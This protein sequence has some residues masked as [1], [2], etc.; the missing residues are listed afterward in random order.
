MYGVVADD[1]PPPA[2][3]DAAMV[4]EQRLMAAPLPN[5]G[6]QC[7]SCG[8]CN[9]PPFQCGV[10]RIH[11]T[12]AEWKDTFQASKTVLKKSNGDAVAA[13][14]AKE[15]G[16][17]DSLHHGHAQQPAGDKRGAGL[18]RTPRHVRVAATRQTRGARTTGEEA[19]V[20]MQ[21]WSIMRM[22]RRLQ[23]STCSPACEHKREAGSSQKVGIGPAESEGECQEVCR[24]GG[25]REDLPES[26]RG[27]LCHS[28]YGVERVAGR[29]R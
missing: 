27:K 24:L 23:V 19:A 6:V 17:Q 3:R 16:E 26:C 1:N 4:F 12:A 9:W 10:A 14:P 2:D 20:D 8:L 13:A 29:G 5:G 18:W 11:F 25:V 21:V 22:G 7:S 15:Q 28:L